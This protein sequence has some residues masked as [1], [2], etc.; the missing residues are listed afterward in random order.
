[1]V[2]KKQKISSSVA[3][4]DIARTIADLESIVRWFSDQ[5]TVDLAKGID[6]F[7]RGTELIKELKQQMGEIENEF[8]E[9][10]R[11]MSD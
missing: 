2:R 11:G 10:K 7:R 9:I 3:S 4:E 5:K 8:R 6:Q 1:M